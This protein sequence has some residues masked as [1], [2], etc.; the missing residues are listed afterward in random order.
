ML[1]LAQRRWHVTRRIGLRIRRIRE[2]QRLTLTALATKAGCTKGSLS[3]I[4]N[5]K[6]NMP[7][8]TLDRLAEALGVALEDLVRDDPG[9]FLRLQG[10][11]PMRGVG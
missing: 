7:V 4:E 3:K 8:E 10:S 1:F 5:G 11:L 6:V 2:H 9:P